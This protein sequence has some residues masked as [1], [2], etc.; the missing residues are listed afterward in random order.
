MFW[1]TNVL[2]LKPCIR[3]LRS[4]FS[5]RS[6][7]WRFVDFSRALQLTGPRALPINRVYVRFRNNGLWHIPNLPIQYPLIKPFILCSSIIL[8]GL[9]SQ[10]YQV[11]IVDKTTRQTS[12][13]REKKN[14]VTFGHHKQLRPAPTASSKSF[15]LCSLLKW[16]FSF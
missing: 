2:T 6:Q 11:T 14:V 15:G 5:A 10:A 13:A 3:T 7:A 16:G 8:R 1:R 12:G 4:L 9:T